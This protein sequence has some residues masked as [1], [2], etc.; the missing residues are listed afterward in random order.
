[1]LN[2][3]RSLASRLC[4]EPGLLNVE[5]AG[6]LGHLAGPEWPLIGRSLLG[7]LDKATRQTGL[8]YLLPL[9]PVCYLPP[10][11]PDFLKVRVCRAKAVDYLVCLTADH[12]F[13]ITLSPTRCT[14]DKCPHQG[15]VVRVSSIANTKQLQERSHN[16]SLAACKSRPE[17]TGNVFLIKW[18]AK[19]LTKS[20]VFNL[21]RW[22]DRVFTKISCPA[23]QD[24]HLLISYRWH[25]E[26]IKNDNRNNSCEELNGLLLVNCNKGQIE[27]EISLP[28]GCTSVIISLTKSHILLQTSSCYGQ[29]T[30]SAE[31]A[32]NGSRLGC[33]QPSTTSSIEIFSLS[34][35]SRLTNYV[36]QVPMPCCLLPGDR[37]IITPA[38]WRPGLTDR[39]QTKVF[40]DQ[41]S[42][43]ARLCGGWGQNSVATETE[44]ME[45]EMDSIYRLGVLHLQP[46]QSPKKL[47]TQLSCPLSPSCVIPNHRG[48]HLFVGCKTHGCVYR[49]DLNSCE[50]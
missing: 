8:N 18:D 24:N 7:S 45:P 26:N 43:Q 14:S 35:C 11:H 4:E 36:M 5:L 48:E 25:A 40:K 31:A 21:G 17:E 12:R 30:S 39:I 50:T 32:H 46:V 20:Q 28:L 10:I 44:F 22:P 42:G 13:L 29:S 6:R 41:K 47:I 37:Y 34:S 33:L 19:Y 1:M 3:L 9:M 16:S 27:G 23:Y 38:T 15:T 2:L 49:Y